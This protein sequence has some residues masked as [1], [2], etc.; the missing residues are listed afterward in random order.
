MADEAVR[1]LL[2]DVKKFI[3]ATELSDLEITC[4]NHIYRVHKLVLCTRSQF[5]ANALKFPGKEHEEGR[6]D[7]PDDE[8]SIIKLMIDYI[9]E[10]EYEPHLPRDITKLAASDDRPKHSCKTGHMTC[11]NYG[12][13]R[14]VCSHHTCGISCAFTCKD[15]VCDSCYPPPIIIPGPSGQLLVHAKLYEIG[16]KYQISGLK[17]LSKFKFEL[18][19]AKFW[20]DQVFAEAANHAFAT[21]PEDDKGL[22]RIVCKTISEHM[23][24]LKKKDVAALMTEYNDLAF[25]LLMEKAEKCGWLN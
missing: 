25:G 5:F 8:P 7:L 14:L 18:A 16:D 13:S 3:K 20:D 19:C 11:P 15:F 21:T 17:E 1:Q 9:Y 12:T 2:A 23:G 24:L 10:A 22:R 4:D 6:I